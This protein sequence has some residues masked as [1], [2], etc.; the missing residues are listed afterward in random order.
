[1]ANIYSDV[2]GS[3]V[4]FPI[5]LS[6]NQLGQTGWYPV[7]G[8]VSLIEENLKAIINYNI[9]QR[10]RQEDFGSRLWEC[11]EEPNVQ[12][13][14]FLVNTFLKEAIIMYEDRVTFVGST[15]TLNGSSIII[16]YHLRVNMTNKA[17]SST[18]TIDK[19]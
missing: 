2:I 11:I 3:G 9:G 10:I 7:E 4:T 1:M 5:Q 12:A 14:K 16:E 8:E 6:T 19:Q 15:V 17:L 13:L 18:L